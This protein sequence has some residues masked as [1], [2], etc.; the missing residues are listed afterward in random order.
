MLMWLDP[1]AEIEQCFSTTHST[2]IT[3][4]AMHQLPEFVKKILRMISFPMVKTLS[5]LKMAVF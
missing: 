2:G 5:L 4:S 1:G 3:I